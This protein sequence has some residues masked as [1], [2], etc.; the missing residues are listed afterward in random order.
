MGAGSNLR[1]KREQDG[2]WVGISLWVEVYETPSLSLFPT[3]GIVAEFRQLL[4]S[5]WEQVAAKGRLVARGANKGAFGYLSPPF[6]EGAGNLPDRSRGIWVR[7]LLIANR[8][9]CRLGACTTVEVVHAQQAV[10]LDRDLVGP[11]FPLVRALAGG[12]GKQNGQ[13]GSEVAAGAIKGGPR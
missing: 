13:P 4:R 7:V 2:I 11:W 5:H 10:V 9:K 8:G 3:R 12:V 6:G 1:S